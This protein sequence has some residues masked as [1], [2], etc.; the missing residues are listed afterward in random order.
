MQRASV[1]FFMVSMIAASSPA[2]ADGL[3]VDSNFIDTSSQ[4]P[5]LCVHF[6]QPLKPGLGAHYED[7]VKVDH[8]S[9]IVTQ[10]SGDNLCI[11]GVPYAKHYTVSLQAGLP[12]QNGDTLASD[13][14]VEFAPGDRPPL[15]AIA[16]NGLY[17]AKR[18]AA[19]LAITSVNIHKLAIHVLRL[20]DLNAIQDFAVSQNS[21]VFDTAQ[22]SIWGYNLTSLVSGQAGVI[23]SG[24]MAVDATP[25][26]AV[27]TL[28]PIA[29]A[30]GQ[31][32][33]RMAAK[34]GVYW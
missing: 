21:N 7:Y 19:G 18:S 2:W 31:S 23:W 17:L 32:G 27:Q 33:D 4:T 12:A 8:Y 29:T 15:V 11:G 22:Q 10:V 5:T 1:A 24:T 13:T 9:G 25:D 14:K 6:T 26:T 34:P 30:I 20:N 28:F 3:T 16:G